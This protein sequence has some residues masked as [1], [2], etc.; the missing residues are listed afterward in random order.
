MEDVVMLVTFARR[1]QGNENTMCFFGS[2][3]AIDVV[4]EMRLTHPSCGQWPARVMTEVPES[5]SV[6]AKFTIVDDEIGFCVLEVK[7]RGRRWSTLYDTSDR[8]GIV[9]HPVIDAIDHFYL[10]DIPEDVAR[11]ITA[12]INDFREARL[13]HMHP[14]DLPELVVDEDDGERELVERVR[15][16]RSI[17]WS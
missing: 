4:L 15:L 13:A 16:G 10:D 2:D 9:R 1:W 7:G 11:G 3:K 8:Q 17:E 5:Y 6:R 12:R 14:K